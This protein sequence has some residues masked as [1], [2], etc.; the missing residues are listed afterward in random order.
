MSIEFLEPG[1]VGISQGD[2]SF[3]VVCIDLE[4]DPCFFPVTRSVAEDIELWAHGVGQLP[5][6][7]PEDLVE[8]LEDGKVTSAYM[9]IEEDEIDLQ[10]G[11][12]AG[13]FH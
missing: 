4:G 6:H 9:E 10:F 11:H 12:L 7:L 8:L 3:N 13:A 1:Y 2:Q 5:D